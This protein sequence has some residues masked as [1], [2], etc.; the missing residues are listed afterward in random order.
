MKKRPKARKTGP[1]LAQ[2][3]NQSSDISDLPSAARPIR[4]HCFAIRHRRFL[5]QSGLFAQRM[6]R[7]F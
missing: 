2:S 7:S 3:A 5:R 4:Y 6:E 1:F